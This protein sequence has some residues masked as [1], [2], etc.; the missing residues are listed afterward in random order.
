M[1]FARELLAHEDDPAARL[2]ALERRLSD[3]DDFWAY[4]AVDRLTDNWDGIVAWYCV[5][6]CQNH[7]YFWYENRAAAVSP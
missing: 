7:N 4:L 5:P 3:I 1:E 6:E 2:A